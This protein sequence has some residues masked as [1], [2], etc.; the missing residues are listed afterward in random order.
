[1]IK[2]IIFDMGGVLLTYDPDF[3]LSQFIE[4]GPDFDLLKSAIFLSDEWALAD[5]GL[6]KGEELFAHV[7]HKI[8]H[9]LHEK[10]QA[11]L[12]GWHKFMIPIEGAYEYLEAMKGKY[13]LLLLS[14]AADTFE[15]IAEI[16]PVFS[17]L[18]EMLISYREHTLKPDRAIYETL[19]KRFALRAEECIFID[20]M[21]ANVAGAKQCGIH[22]I[23]FDSDYEALKQKIEKLL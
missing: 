10:A 8:P 17:L 23:L 18:D 20:D 12:Q 5:K 6:I 11:V 16:R 19:L 3:I 1:M 22:G 4:N 13:K 2:N 9:R 15:K 14:N 7:A 21:P